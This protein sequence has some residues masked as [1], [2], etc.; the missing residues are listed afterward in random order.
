M[1]ERKEKMKHAQIDQLIG[2]IDKH[3]L[4]I[5][6][7]LNEVQVD[8]NNLQSLPS[9]QYLVD[10]SRVHYSHQHWVEDDRWNLPAL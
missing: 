2:N 5:F 10:G 1:K 3:I 8:I 4:H 7:K 9:L 6:Q